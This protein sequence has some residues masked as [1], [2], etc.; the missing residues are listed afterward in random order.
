VM[1]IDTP[2]FPQQ[3]VATDN[4]IDPPEDHKLED[5]DQGASG[6]LSPYT[7]YPLEYPPQGGSRMA[8]PHIGSI[9]SRDLRAL[10]K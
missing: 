7:D 1:Q 5:G 4:L 6:P 10:K 3:A 9:G 2:N 8:E